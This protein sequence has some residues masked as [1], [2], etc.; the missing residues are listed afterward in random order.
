MLGTGLVAYAITMDG[1][2]VSDAKTILLTIHIIVLASLGLVQF[3]RNKSLSS[4][5]IFYFFPQWLRHSS[6][7]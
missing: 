4:V 1:V 6:H 7:G 3:E 2:A 5:M